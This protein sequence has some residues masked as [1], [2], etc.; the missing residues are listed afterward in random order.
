[1][2]EKS[3]TDPDTS[4]QR[5]SVATIQTIPVLSFAE[6]RNHQKVIPKMP[7]SSAQQNQCCHSLLQ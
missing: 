7:R 1:V 6:G 2:F 5:L 3:K 4:Q